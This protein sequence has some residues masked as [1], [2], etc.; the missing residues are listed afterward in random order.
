MEASDQELDDYDIFSA[1]FRNCP[2]PA[3]AAMQS[4]CPVAHSDRR[5]GSWMVA[6][7]DDVRDLVRAASTELQLLET[8]PDVIGSF[9]FQVDQCDDP[10][11]EGLFIT[12]NAFNWTGASCTHRGENVVVDLC[13]SSQFPKPYYYYLSATVLHGW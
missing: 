10:E 5:G 3:W 8:T 11:L 12:T 13:K 9:V 4:S 1:Q 2:Y 6:R 7:Y